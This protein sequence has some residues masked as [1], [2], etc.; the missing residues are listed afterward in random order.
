MKTRELG[1]L[2]LL[3]A[4]WGASFMFIKIALRDMAPLTVATTRVTL[5]S[6]GL[7]VFYVLAQMRRPANAASPARPV[8]WRALVGP[9]LFAGLFNAVIPYICLTW[10]ETH[11][12]S[13]NAAILNA[14]TPLFTAIIAYL[15]PSQVAERLPPVRALGLGVGFLGVVV[16]VAGSGSSGSDDITLVWLGHGAVLVMALSYAVAGLYARRAFAG[17]PT[18]VPA[19]GQNTAAAV[20]L[21]PLAGLFAPI[22]HV[23]SAEA[24]AALL[25]LGL[26]G[27]AIAYV[28][29]FYLLDRVGATRTVL[30]T[31]LLPVTA[32]I[33]AVLLLGE[34]IGLQAILGLILVLAGIT[35][36]TGGAVM[37]WQAGR[38]AS[39]H[40]A[41]P[42]AGP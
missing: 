24:I 41:Q 22:T 38:R 23:P 39:G 1:V 21:L 36:T 40:A 16:L 17:L 30:V 8:V 31:Y 27:T 6:L 3:A 20:I 34:T 42:K 10:G 11:I 29:Y 13:S 37:V 28:L 4:I 26:G 7:I 14:T 35:I 25:A 12:P 5:G 18:L 19:L 33:Y 2:L 9:F 32:L 15:L